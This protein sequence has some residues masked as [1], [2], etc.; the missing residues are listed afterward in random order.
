MIEEGLKA[1]INGGNVV[2]AVYG[3]YGMSFHFSSYV[4]YG[5]LFCDV[6]YHLEHLGIRHSKNIVYSAYL[7]LLNIGLFEM[8]YMG[9]FAFFQMNRNVLEW[10]VTDIFEACVMTNFSFVLLGVMTLLFLMADSVMV[11][12]KEIVGRAF[13][14]RFNTKVLVVAVLTVVSILVWVYYPLPIE[15]LRIGEWTSS[16]LFPQTHYAYKN[17]Q[18][19][20]QNDL[21]HSINLTTKL[22]FMVTQY[23]LLTCLQPSREDSK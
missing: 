14:F 19:Y 5:V 4:I 9:S 7:T 17:S 21:L 6:S 3:I 13:Q 11:N 2:E 12:G 18:L 15:T 10:F 1:F 20:M 8:W 23:C 16:T 22:L